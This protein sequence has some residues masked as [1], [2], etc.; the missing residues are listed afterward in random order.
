MKNKKLLLI[1]LINASI[2]FLLLIILEFGFRFIEKIPKTAISFDVNFHP[3][4]MWTSDLPVGPNEYA[5]DTYKSERYKSQMQPNNLQFASDYDYEFVPDK[6]FY[7][8]LNKDYNTRIVIITGGSAVHG[9]SASDNNHTIS[10]QM[11]KYL[12]QFQSKYK[13]K[14]I[15]MGMGSWI[16]MQ[17]Y[18]CLAIYGTRFDPD[19]VIVV[20]GANDFSSFSD[21]SAG[22]GNPMFWPTMLYY[23]NG[24][25]IRNGLDKFLIKNSSIYRVLT[26][27][28]LDDLQEVDDLKFNLENKDP[29]FRVVLDTKWDEIDKQVDFYLYAHELILHQFDKAKYIFSPQPK[30]EAYGYYYHNYF[31]ATDAKEKENNKKIM[32]DGVK[33]IYEN[34]KG[35]DVLEANNGET[36]YYFFYSSLF[37]HEE[38]VWKYSQSQKKDV[39]YKNP[40]EWFVYDKGSAQELRKKYF[41]DSVHYNNNGHEFLG[42]YYAVQIIERD[43]SKNESFSINKQILNSLHDLVKKVEGS[44]R[45]IHKL[46]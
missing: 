7:K 2:F 18:I 20:D 24:K 12:N 9:H 25:K 4:I 10:A 46:Y 38:L 8:K 15:N 27:S 30:A 17:E 35:K 13:Y 34:N 39:R 29:R 19:W 41:S 1:I 31:L 45:E 43:F 28:S 5:F 37:K 42:I 36:E 6:D 32:L 3:Y 11:E 40:E 23:L 14:V 26:K 44:D 16:A 22:V 33:R 21:H